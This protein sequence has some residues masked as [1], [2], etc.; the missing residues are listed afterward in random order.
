VSKPFKVDF[1]PL[2]R[3]LEVADKCESLIEQRASVEISLLELEFNPNII[4]LAE[5]LA[6]L[7]ILREADAENRSPRYAAALEPDTEPA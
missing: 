3:L 5:V 1:Q 4:P 2:I 6:T 7:T